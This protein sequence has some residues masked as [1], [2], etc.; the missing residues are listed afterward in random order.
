MEELLLLCNKNGWPTSG[1]DAGNHGHHP[2]LDFNLENGFKKLEKVISAVWN[3]KEGS[4]I[5][6][7]FGGNPKSGPD[8]YK[9]TVDI[10]P[11]KKKD[12]ELFWQELVEVVNTEKYDPLTNSCQYLLKIAEFLA[13]KE[14]GLRISLINGKTEETYNI[15][16]SLAAEMYRWKYYTELFESVGF[17][18]KEFS[19]ERP[20]IFWYLSVPNEEEVEEVLKKIFDTFVQKWS[21]ELPT[22][23]SEEMSFKTMAMVM[24]RK[25]GNDEAGRK[26]LAEWIEKNFMKPFS[27]MYF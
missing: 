5:D 9:T 20:R 15:Q 11:A 12:A 17:N 19:D 22:E 4:G 25:Y 26:R 1:C 8:W 13:D 27:E 10:Y 16:F 14:S 3:F 18:T 24:R 2:Y 21:L 6:I 23:V 7:L